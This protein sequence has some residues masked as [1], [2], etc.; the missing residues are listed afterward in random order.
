MHGPPRPFRAAQGAPA[1]V[2]VGG[3]DGAAFPSGYGEENDLCLRVRNAGY[4]LAVADDVYVWHSKSASFG[5]ARSGT[6]GTTVR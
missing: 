6:D 4:Q 5:A 2:E 3:M 1:S